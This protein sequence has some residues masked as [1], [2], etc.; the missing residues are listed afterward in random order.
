MVMHL[1][2]SRWVALHICV[3][4]YLC[5]YACVYTCVYVPVLPQLHLHSG[6]CARDNDEQH[7]VIGD[8]VMVMHLL[9]SRWVCA[10]YLRFFTASQ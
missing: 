3:C 1:L 10:A 9:S 7:A 2:S 4:V 8:N 5:F 6:T